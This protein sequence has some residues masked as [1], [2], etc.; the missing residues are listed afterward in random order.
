[1]LL[2]ARHQL[3]FLLVMITLCTWWSSLLNTHIF[4]YF[5]SP[6]FINLD[7][8]NTM[9]DC[10]RQLQVLKFI[11]NL[12]WGGFPNIFHLKITVNMRM[13]ACTFFVRAFK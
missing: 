6:Y 11:R 1:M 8:E 3:D 9:G 12:G 7:L 5:S 2:V 4:V 10:Q 13:S